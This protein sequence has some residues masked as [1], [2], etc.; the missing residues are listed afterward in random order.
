MR[1][2]TVGGQEPTDTTEKHSPMTTALSAFQV[3]C[4]RVIGRLDA[5]REQT[6]YGLGIKRE[7]EARYGQE[8][9][10][11]RLYPNLDDLVEAGLVEKTALDKR[12]NGYRLTQRGRDTL[13]DGLDAYLEDVAAFDGHHDLDAHV[14]V[15]GDA[16]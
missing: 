6:P 4:L 3:Q 11:G 8:V 12:T 16:S 7:L 15:D 13:L 5:E 14:R 10:H 9:N 2:N 1:N